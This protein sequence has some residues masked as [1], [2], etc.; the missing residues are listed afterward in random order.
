MKKIRIL[1]GVLLLA[2]F[3]TGCVPTVDDLFQL[4]VPKPEYQ[5]LQN[6]VTQRLGD[7][8]ELT[9]PLGGELRTTMHFADL[10]GDGRDEG[11]ILL[12]SSASSQMLILIYAD[13]GSRYEFLTEY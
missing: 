6:E 4:P 1:V 12:R 11:V 7:G 8:W 5:E 9:Y 10:T 2:L 3:L 13:T